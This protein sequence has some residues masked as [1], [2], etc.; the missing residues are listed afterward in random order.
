MTRL[1]SG[2]PRIPL[3]VLLSS[4]LLVSCADTTSMNPT[5]VPVDGVAAAKGG[6]PGPPGG[7]GGDGGDDGGTDGADPVVD[8]TN[9]MEAPQDTTLDVEVLGDNFE[10]G[11][12]AEFLLN[13]TETADITTNETRFVNEKKLIANITVSFDAATELYDVR[14]T[15][16]PGRKGVGLELFAI[17]RKGNPNQ[18]ITSVRFVSP[19][20]DPAVRIFGDGSGDYIDSVEGVAIGVGRQFVF[21]PDDGDVNNGRFSGSRTLCLQFTADQETTGTGIPSVLAEDL[22]ADGVVCTKGDLRTVWH[23]NDDL[24]LEGMT[25]GQTIESEG[26]Y[27]WPDPKRQDQFKL[28]FFCRDDRGKDGG[29]T[30][31]TNLLEVTMLTDDTTG[32]SWRLSFDPS[33]I[34][35]LS[36]NRIK[37][38][39]QPFEPIAAFHMP[40]DLTVR[41][42][43]VE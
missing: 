8:A 36:A 16:P 40:F 4:L 26:R 18:P 2:T 10:P 38:A 21:G 5:A 14:V 28:E 41:V 1:S 42:G 43:P 6:V 3:F 25:V 24:G 34:A 7:D 33:L 37:G 29:G 23:E 9:P 22:D 12:V 27:I 17:V 13:E 19:T 39:P 30:T 35:V 32:K 11:S 31:C 15:T 20:A